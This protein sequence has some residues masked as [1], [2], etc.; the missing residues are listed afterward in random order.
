ME[1]NGEKLKKFAKTTYEKGKETFSKYKEDAEEK[2]KKFAKKGKEAYSKYQEG[3]GERAEKKLEKLKAK[4]TYQQEKEKAR[5]QV[6]ETK[7]KIATV[8][9]EMKEAKLAPYREKF[10]KLQT[11]SKEKFQQLN[12]PTKSKPSFMKQSDP[13]GLNTGSS[14]KQ[15]NNPFGLSMGQTPSRKVNNPFGL[16]MG[17]TKSMPEVDILG[18]TTRKKRKRTNR[19][20][21]SMDKF[22]GLK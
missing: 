17:N 22:L 21:M 6:L 8:K 5:L 13:L 19:R 11:L 10:Q 4:N 1:L 2:L 20:A 18:L 7:G 14:S 15:V 3:A 9:A 16:S 12:T